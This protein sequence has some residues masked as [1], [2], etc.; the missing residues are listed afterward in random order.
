MRNSLQVGAAGFMLKN[1][2]ITKLI[3]AIRLVHAGESVYDIELSRR[4]MSRL[5]QNGADDHKDSA[6]L[7]PR[8]LEVLKQAAKGKTNKEIAHDLTISQR[9]VQ[10][11]LANIFRKLSVGSRTEAVLHALKVGWLTPD[12]LP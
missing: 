9:T 3:S 4:I 12:D 5:Y 10:S 6:E 1:A 2:P 11:H 7:L 8:E